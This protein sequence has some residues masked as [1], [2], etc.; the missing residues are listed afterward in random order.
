MDRMLSRSATWGKLTDPEALAL[1]RDIFRADPE[2]LAHLLGDG[3]EA[4]RPFE[5]EIVREGVNV[6][7]RIIPVRLAAGDDMK[8]V[9]EPGTSSDPIVIVDIK[10]GD[11]RILPVGTIDPVTN[12]TLSSQR[13]I[14]AAI[15]QGHFKLEW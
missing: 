1:L 13:A 3:L 12:E 11:Y 15:L 2:K 6:T 5:A 4:R 9:M 8:I 10:T 14:V 7:E